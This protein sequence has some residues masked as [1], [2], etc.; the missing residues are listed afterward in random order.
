MNSKNMGWNLENSYLNIPE[1]F[2][3]KVQL[4]LTS[5]AELVVVNK[6]LA[7]SIGLNSETLTS[8]E[9]IEIFSGNKLPMGG[10]SL[11]QAYAGHQFGN[12]TMLGDGRALLI[13]EQ[14]TPQGNR[15]DIQ[16]KG[17]GKTPY[18][19]GG[20]GRASLSSMLR[21]YIISEAMHNLDIPSTRSLAV[22][23][24]GD[25]IVRQTRLPGAILT[26]VAKSHIR[27]GTFEYA[28]RYGKAE[29]IKILA[30]Y[31]IK[32][33][34]PELILEKNPYI[35][36]LKK[37]IDV[38]ASLIA[39]WQLVGFIHGVMNT[40]NMTISGETIDYGPC[41]FMDI[42][43]P[44]T[45][46]SSIDVNG[47]YAYNN[48][49]KIGQWNLARF[50]ETLLTLVDENMEESI[51]LAQEALEDFEHR[52]NQYW[53]DGMRKKLGIFDEEKEDEPLIEDLLELMETYKV[54]YT[55]TF[56]ALTSDKF[57]KTDL[58]A[59][60][61]FKIWYDRWNNRLIRQKQS[62]EESKDLMRKSNPAI[63]PR[64]NLLEEALKLA[65]KEK[66][67]SLFYKLLK[68]LSN[69]YDYENIDDKYTKTPQAPLIPYKTYC[70][71]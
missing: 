54:D 16:L 47:R 43:N 52:F 55:N 18:S 65:E 20:D 69:P 68:V 37:V 67:Y 26:R 33:H 57:N 61:E 13:G 9:A 15:L 48:Q 4:N 59:S 19:R 45:V 22:V 53:I 56:V 23:L 21:E 27:V 3:K 17:S 6:L 38:Q 44:K 49:E 36:L 7:E 30:D 64:N 50:A 66:D 28:A 40:D 25:T 39:K 63:I 8:K 24:S 51:K 42:Y 62:K 5:K 11:A 14:V 32:R 1:I 31:T 29:D 46:F 34:Y 58:F 41:A 12:F 71:T 35:A 10:I 70:G 60:N 2:Y